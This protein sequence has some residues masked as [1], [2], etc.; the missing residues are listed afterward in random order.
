MS[1]TKLTCTDIA[2]VFRKFATMLDDKDR[3]KVISNNDG[4]NELMALIMTMK[5]FA[6]SKAGGVNLLTFGD[7]DDASEPVEKALAGWE[8]ATKNVNTQKESHNA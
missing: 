6:W 7:A 4:G 8:F 1:T 3:V 2:D 5:V